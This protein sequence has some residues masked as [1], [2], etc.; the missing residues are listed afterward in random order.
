MSTP[1]VKHRYEL[2]LAGR[3]KQVNIMYTCEHIG[4]D[5]QPDNL[6]DHLRY[7]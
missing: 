6:R 3:Q 1:A 4:F 7:G 2:S 5:N